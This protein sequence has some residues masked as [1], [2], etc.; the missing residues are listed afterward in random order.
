MAVGSQTLEKSQKNECTTNP[1]MDFLLHYPKLPT[2]LKSLPNKCMLRRAVIFSIFIL[3]FSLPLVSADFINPSFENSSGGW[4]EFTKRTSSQHYTGSYAWGFTYFPVT[5]H[6]ANAQTVDLTGIDS[7]TVWMK[8]GNSAS[9]TE[10]QVYTTGNVFTGCYAHAMSL[11]WTQ[12]TVDVSNLTGPHIIKCMLAPSSGYI[13]GWFDDL[14]LVAGSSVPVLPS[15][16]GLIYFTNDPYD[17]TETAYYTTLVNQT[18]DIGWHVEPD[19]YRMFNFYKTVVVTELNAG[20]YS[21]GFIPIQT[22]DR[23]QFDEDSQPVVYQ[24]MPMSVDIPT[25]LQAKYIKRTYVYT[26]AYPYIVEHC[27]GI[28]QGVVGSAISLLGSYIDLEPQQ[29]INETIDIDYAYHSN[30]ETVFDTVETVDDL[31]D[32]ITEAPSYQ[33]ILNNSV[34]YTPPVN[35]T[36]DLDDDGQDDEVDEDDDDNGQADDQDTDEDGQPDVYDPEDTNPDNDGTD[37]DND[38]DG[39]GLDEKTDIDDDGDGDPD[40][41]DPD[42]DGDE[43]PD[44][45]ENP[46]NSTYNSN[47]SYVYPTSGSNTTLN[48]TD[49]T[50]YYDFVNSSVDSLFAP[51]RDLAELSSLPFIGL[52][53]H[54]NNM[55][56]E[57][58]SSEHAVYIPIYSSALKPIVDNIPTKVIKYVTIN[59]VLFIILILMGRD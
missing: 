15:S 23:Q 43:I 8:N 53:S 10:L 6:W 48:T 28:L 52:T 3:L 34:N 26:A 16:D 50:G 12:Y 2:A 29:I 32:L 44:Q 27:P 13:G 19:A 39:D 11:N 46:S 38:V 7:I 35:I 37:L 30:E 21:G 57:L 59:L 54:I 41:T 1:D 36:S 56:S 51:I 14:A 42:D 31:I 25:V 17:V 22:L 49:I 55:S 5:T 47:Q 33:D 24:N 58:E 18:A 9:I 45:V 40:I 4:S 20:N